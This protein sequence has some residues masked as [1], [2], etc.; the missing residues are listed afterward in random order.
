MNWR[1]K[2][3]IQRACNILPVGKQTLYRQLQRHCGGLVK[4]YDHGFLLSETARMAGMLLNAG[5]DLRGAVAME[6]GTGWRVDIPI[7]LY[8]CGV[9]RTITCDINRYL[10]KRLTLDTVRY[11]GANS[12]R[13]S[14]LFP[15]VDEKELQWR[16]DDLRGVN[17]LEHLFRTTG[18]EY[19]AP[20]DC[21][22]TN[23]PDRSIDL[24][25]SYTVFEHISAP[26]LE[27]ILI[28]ANRLLSDRGVA[29]HHIDLG[30]H[31]AQVDKSITPANFLQFADSEWNSYSRTP[32]SYHNR[33][34]VNEYRELFR[35]AL[36]EILYW[37]EHI[38]TPSLEALERGFPLA[39]RFRDQPARMLSVALLDV[40]S[41]P[42][43]RHQR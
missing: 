6:V 15:F 31:F 23:F 9:R 4:G 32:W 29:F 30:D 14:G 8:L 36:Q 3:A 12:E 21:A 28:E 22:K 33:L 20:Y 11:V 27:T 39:P 7:A 41:R 43:E 13:I 10:D 16:I 40:I 19:Y 26:T 37:N 25:Y 5:F 34:R 18:I 38:D 24:H 42:A 2:A 17:T 35:R 1:L